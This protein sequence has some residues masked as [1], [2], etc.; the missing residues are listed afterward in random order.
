MV[1]ATGDVNP[2][3]ST[4]GFAVERDGTQIMV[5]NGYAYAFFG[6]TLPASYRNTSDL[7]TSIHVT[8]SSVVLGNWSNAGGAIVES[9]GRHGIALESAYF[10]V[11]G[12]TTNDTDA[13]NAVYQIIY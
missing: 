5:A 9:V 7:S 4:T 8:S 12:G 13:V 6:G 1:N 10:Y 3:G 2:W 11:V